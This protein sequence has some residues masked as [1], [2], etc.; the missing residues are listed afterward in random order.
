MQAYTEYSTPP[1]AQY[2]AYGSLKELP[3]WKDLCAAMC[4]HCRMHHLRPSNLATLASSME[5]ACRFPETPT[6]KISL[7]TIGV[8]TKVANPWRQKKYSPSL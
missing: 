6:L 7:K 5:E 1:I 3:K 4:R 2:W 8:C